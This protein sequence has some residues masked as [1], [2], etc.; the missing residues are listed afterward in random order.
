MQTEKNP[1][2]LESGKLKGNY[3]SQQRIITQWGQRRKKKPSPGIQVTS[4]LRRKERSTWSTENDITMAFSNME[5]N[6]LDTEGDDNE[7]LGAKDN[8]NRFRTGR[9]VKTQRQ[10]FCS[11]TAQID[12]LSI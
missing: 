1:R 8:W 6:G 2:M 4:V 12:I 9:K 10:R 3:Q 11:K 7:V 5:N